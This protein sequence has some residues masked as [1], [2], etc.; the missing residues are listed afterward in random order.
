MLIFLAMALASSDAIRAE[1]WARK[2]KPI[3]TCSSEADCDEKWKRASDWIRK[4]TRFQFAV[5]RPDLLATYGAIYAN[6]DL[7]FVLTRRQRADGTTEIAAR[8]W[9]GNVVA[10]NP[11][12]KNAIAALTREVG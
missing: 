7:S 4:S 3:A 8:A 11:K 6:T 10:C 12:P 1:E 5:D 2:A 9:C